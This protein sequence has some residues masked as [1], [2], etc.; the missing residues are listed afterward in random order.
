MRLVDLGRLN[1]IPVLVPRT[2]FVGSWCC[3]SD[4]LAL[5]SYCDF[6]CCREVEEETRCK[7]AKTV[8]VVVAVWQVSASLIE[9]WLSYM[10]KTLLFS[11]SLTQEVCLTRCTHANTFFHHF[12]FTIK[13]LIKALKHLIIFL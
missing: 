9:I 8:Q 12:L 6:V 2:N 5:N 11:C 3:Q 4:K 1:N 7:T 13:I 10:H